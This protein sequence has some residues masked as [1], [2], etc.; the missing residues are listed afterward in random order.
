MSYFVFIEDAQGR[1]G[2]VGDEYFSFVQAQDKADRFE[3]VTHIIEAQNVTL[4]K[5]SLKGKLS[6][7]EGNLSPLYKNV[8]SK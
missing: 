7:R 5:R 8:R 3:G 4:A 2:R 6:K 1:L